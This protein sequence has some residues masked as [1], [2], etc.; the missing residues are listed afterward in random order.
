M[1]A[2][3]PFQNRGCFKVVT[4]PLDGYLIVGGTGVNTHSRNWYDQ[5]GSGNGY[6]SIDLQVMYC[7]SG[8]IFHLQYSNRD[9]NWCRD[10]WELDILTLQDGTEIMPRLRISYDTTPWLDFS[11]VPVVARGH[12]SF[13]LWFEQWL[14][15]GWGPTWGTSNTSHQVQTIR[16]DFT[17]AYD[18]DM[19]GI[20]DWT[21]GWEYSPLEFN[22]VI[23]DWR[24]IGNC[25]N[26][27]W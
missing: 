18:P 11:A 1:N 17:V 13:V 12:H 4:A 26:K 19:L 15:F 5:Y 10:C 3:P 27:I 6:A 8:E 24:P 2:P 7:P 9:N 14:D 21:T 25:L 20:G 22:S 23:E 16:L